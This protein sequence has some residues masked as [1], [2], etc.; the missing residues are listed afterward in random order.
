MNLQAEVDGQLLA[1]ER[2]TAVARRSPCFGFGDLLWS[3]TPDM[4]TLANDLMDDPGVM[5]E[6]GRRVVVFQRI[7]GE[8]RYYAGGWCLGQDRAAPEQDR[9]IMAEGCELGVFESVADA[10]AFS[11]GYLVIERSFTALPVPR[12]VRYGRHPEAVEAD[13]EPRAAPDAGRG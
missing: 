13:A 5:F 3:P 2:I 8:L 4:Q 11:E 7:G 12:D 10:L 9:R 6:T 1:V